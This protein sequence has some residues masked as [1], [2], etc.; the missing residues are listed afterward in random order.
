MFSVFPW[1]VTVPLFADIWLHDT[2]KFQYHIPDI[3]VSFIFTVRNKMFSLLCGESEADDCSHCLPFF[4]RSKKTHLSWLPHHSWLLSDM[5]L[6]FFQILSTVFHFFP[7]F[8][9]HLNTLYMIQLQFHNNLGNTKFLSW[10]LWEWFSVFCMVVKLFLACSLNYECYLLKF[11]SKGK[12]HP[13][14]SP[15]SWI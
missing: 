13:I 14:L 3:A 7:L 11:H 8:P 10:L 4:L 12:R 9:C 5:K 2:G 1:I 6:N 15:S